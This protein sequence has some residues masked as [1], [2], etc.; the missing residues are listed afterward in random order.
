MTAER[1]FKVTGAGGLDHSLLPMTL[2]RKAKKFESRLAR[3]ERARGQSLE[4]VLRGG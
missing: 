4:S 2:W 1:A 3:I